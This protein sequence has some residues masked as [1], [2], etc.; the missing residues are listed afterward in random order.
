MINLK[1]K[2]NY[3]H[4][5]LL[6]DVN[7]ERVLVSNKISFGEKNYKYI[8]GYLYDDHKVKRLLIMLPKAT[9]YVKRYDGQ[10]KG[11]YFLIEDDDILEKHN[12]IWD[13]VSADIKKELIA[14]LC[15]IKII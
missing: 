14:S 4:K 3:R 6:G 15:I 2:R 11:I 12:T 8:V 5:T 7:I 13:K 10:I 1:K 9:A